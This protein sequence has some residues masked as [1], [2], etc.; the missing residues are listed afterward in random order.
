[1]SHFERELKAR[2]SEIE[3]QRLCRFLR[4]INSAQG[5]AIQIDGQPFLNFSSNDYL[6]LA[7]DQRVKEAAIEAIREF[8][9]GSG[10]WRLVCGLLAAHHELGE[11]LAEF[12]G[13]EAALVFS[14]GYAKALRAIPAV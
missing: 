7:N 6:R 12:I 4:R 3:E 1:M 10:A 2:L 8:V 11:I 9:A 5:P 14:S 13:S